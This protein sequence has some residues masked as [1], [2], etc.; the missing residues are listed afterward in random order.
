MGDV[1]ENALPADRV[2]DLRFITRVNVEAVCATLS[3]VVLGSPA[4]MLGLWLDPDGPAADP[5]AVVL[6]TEAQ[7]LRVLVGDFPHWDLWMPR[8]GEEHPLSTDPRALE[9]YAD[10][11]ERLLGH[12][13]QRQVRDPARWSWIE[14]LSGSPKNLRSSPL[15][16]SSWPTSR[17]PS[18]AAS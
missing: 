2:D 13:T 9:G 12:L 6:G 10:A 15:L 18:S 7:R 3:G 11:A 5:V 14:R 17:T 4:C 1:A 16:Q 8:W